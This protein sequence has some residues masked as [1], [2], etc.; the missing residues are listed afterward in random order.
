MPLPAWAIPICEALIERL[1]EK[2]ARGERLEAI[3]MDALLDELG[4]NEIARAAAL[5]AARRR[6]EERESRR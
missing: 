3:T 2:L 5:E 1:V 6:I 4:R